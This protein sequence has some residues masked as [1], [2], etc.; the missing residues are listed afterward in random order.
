MHGLYYD[1]P[2]DLKIIGLHGK[3]KSGKN[4]LGEHALLPLGY[5]PLAFADQLKVMSV[6]KG[7]IPVEAAFYRDKT[8]EERRFLQEEGTE[9]GRDVYGQDYWL[10]FFETWIVAHASAGVR[11]F[12]VPD[13]RFPNEMEHVQALGGI[14][15]KITGRGGLT[16]GLHGHRSETEL[17][18]YADSMFDAIIDNTPGRYDA[19][20]NLRT[21]GERFNDGI[22]TTVRAA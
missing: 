5:F 11:K 14:I 19:V 12:Y 20:E 7:L 17:D 6:I 2:D 16:N 3:S 18:G 8:P 4:Y 22:V 21:I 9:R 10:R 13:V 15:V 1:L